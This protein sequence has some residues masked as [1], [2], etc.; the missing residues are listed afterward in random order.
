[1]KSAFTIL[2][3]LSFVGIAVFGVFAMNHGDNY[4]HNGCLAKTAQ[5]IDCPKATGAISFLNFH[6][7]A[8][9]KFSTATLADNFANALLLFLALILVIRLKIIAN[10][11]PASPVL[12]TNYHRRRFFES[13]SFPYQRELARWLALRKNSPASL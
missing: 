4:G 7:D 2:L 5:K 10:I 11:Q 9:K 1:M 8:F 13:P 6:L 3:I 12:V